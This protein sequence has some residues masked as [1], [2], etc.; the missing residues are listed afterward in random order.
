VEEL[1][2]LSIQEW[3]DLGLAFAYSQRYQRSSTW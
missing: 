3:I 2:D 1:Y